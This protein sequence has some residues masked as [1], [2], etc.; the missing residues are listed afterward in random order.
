MA[1]GNLQVSPRTWAERAEFVDQRKDELSK[2]QWR[3]IR[4]HVHMNVREIAKLGRETEVI[5]STQAK[6]TSETTTRFEALGTHVDDG[7]EQLRKDFEEEKKARHAKNALLER[8][9]AALKDRLGAF[10]ATEETRHE[11]TERSIALLRM[12]A[13][14]TN[15]VVL[16]R[17]AEIEAS[18]SSHLATVVSEMKTSFQHLQTSVTDQLASMKEMQH[19]NELAANEAL[20]LERRKRDESMGEM[21]QKLQRRIAEEKTSRENACQFLQEMIEERTASAKGD[22]EAA[23]GFVTDLLNNERSKREQQLVVLQESLEALLADE[24]SLRKAFCDEMGGHL[25]REK[26]A[27]EAH[28]ESAQNLI[29]AERAARDAHTKDLHEKLSAFKDNHQMLEEEMAKE[30]KLRDAAHTDLHQLVHGH[31]GSIKDLLHEE[32]STRAAHLDETI[33]RERLE[34][35]KMMQEMFEKC[36]AEGD[37][38]LIAKIQNEESER[39]A[40]VSALRGM[41]EAEVSSREKDIDEVREII[42]AEREIHASHRGEFEARLKQAHDQIDAN[43]EVVHRKI[44]DHRAE[45]EAHHSAHAQQV[46]DLLGA[47]GKTRSA[48]HADILEQMGLIRAEMNSEFQRRDAGTA[49]LRQ[50]L[51]AL[52]NVVGEGELADMPEAPAESELKT[53]DR[54]VRGGVSRQPE[55]AKRQMVPLADR[56]MAMERRLLAAVENEALRRENHVADMKDLIAS[57]AKTRAGFH[58]AHREHADQMH[59][60]FEHLHSLLENEKTERASHLDDHRGERDDMHA[61]L[62]KRL[63]KICTDHNEHVAKHDALQTTMND[64]MTGVV[65]TFRELIASENKSRTD[66]ARTFSEDIE[67]LRRD[68]WQEIEKEGSLR[69][70]ESNDMRE[71]F[72]SRLDNLE[73]VLAYGEEYELDRASSL[74][75]LSRADRSNFL[76]NSYSPHGRVVTLQEMLNSLEQRLRAEVSREADFRQADRSEWREL[77]E[78]MTQAREELQSTVKIQFEKERKTHEAKLQ[79]EIDKL[80]RDIEAISNAHSKLSLEVDQRETVLTNNLT[81]DISSVKQDLDDE[82]TQR[83]LAGK[84]CERSLMMVTERLRDVEAIDETHRQRYDLALAGLKKDSKEKHDL[85]SE[86][87]ASIEGHVERALPAALTDMKDANNKMHH[88]IRDQIDAV[89]AMQ[90]THMSSLVEQLSVEKATRDEMFSDLRSHVTDRLTEEKTHRDTREVMF[91]TKISARLAEEKDERDAATRSL[92]QSLSA[93]RTKRENQ[94]VSTQEASAV[95]FAEARRHADGK[96]ADL[97]AAIERERDAREAH[98]VEMQNLYEEV[99]SAR[100]AHAQEVRGQFEAHRSAYRSLHDEAEAARDAQAKDCLAQVHSN[101]EALRNMIEDHARLR[102]EHVA[103]LHKAQHEERKAREGALDQ[104]RSSRETLEKEKIDAMHKDHNARLKQVEASRAGSD[105][106]I[107]GKMADAAFRLENIEKFLGRSASDPATPRSHSTLHQALEYFETNLKSELLRET[108]ARQN[109]TAVVQQMI[110][111]EAQARENLSRFFEEVLEEHRVRIA[112]ACNEKFN[113]VKSCLVE[114][115]STA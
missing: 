101:H 112:G 100:E 58:A 107:A 3:L 93:E 23:I 7:L 114:A 42:G 20:V 62:Q 41:I 94:L 33:D 34:R 40:C 76:S 30:R 36:R 102:D 81:K 64:M 24:R 28:H 73:A 65:G 77:F 83:I 79:E 108:N 6:F 70:S 86:R 103:K 82:R 2:D 111:K 91:Q 32:R 12:E 44:D 17:I 98:R 39:E 59:G 57:E 22:S 47:E 72:S 105:A 52:E 92:T 106:E 104:E 87:I 29:E 113:S 54:S 66:Q 71:F 31:H 9:V 10:A 8:E 48:H 74:R 56:F 95:G 69:E 60:K 38:V 55:K 13:K 25:Q 53:N 18:V 26:Q 110:G 109:D 21:S 4:D 11:A 80:G 99:R 78:G 61:S 75:G 43:H 88:S 15:S 49:G 85:T 45:R 16:E 27:R 35:E 89:K 37:A 5:K 97:K 50:Q 67:S 14:D 90:E 84:A 68:V 46:N 1:E 63:D 19:A 115:L 96:H 51:V